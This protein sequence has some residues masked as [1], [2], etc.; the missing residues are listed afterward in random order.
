MKGVNSLFFMKFNKKSNAIYFKIVPNI[1]A[2]LE[3]LNE[4]QL[5]EL[6]F[7][8]LN[9]SITILR[10][11]DDNNVPSFHF[12]V[13]RISTD[14]H[15]IPIKLKEKNQVHLKEEIE[16][17]IATLYN[18]NEI[19]EKLHFNPMLDIEVFFERLKDEEV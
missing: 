2:L 9:T 4:S 19:N 12:W 13:H 10:K 8:V 3:N 17:V 7:I 18:L 16:K 11:L 6:G 5:Y 1:K 14:I 15:N